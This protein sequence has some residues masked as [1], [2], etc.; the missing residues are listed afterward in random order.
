MGKTARS[1]LGQVREQLAPQMEAIRRSF[2]R[3]SVDE[4]I[5]DL[6]ST[7]NLSVEKVEKYAAILRFY[8]DKSAPDLEKLDR[9]SAILWEALSTLIEEA[10]NKIE[11]VFSEL[12]T[13]VAGVDLTKDF[14]FTYSKCEEVLQ[15]RI[16]ENMA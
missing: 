7:Q 9:N 2:R 16:A 12:D 3:N 11:A 6:T 10:S 8:D 4:I 14:P 13:L 15:E 5:K 1:R